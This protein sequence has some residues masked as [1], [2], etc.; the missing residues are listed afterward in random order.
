MAR[1]RIQPVIDWLKRII[2]E[3]RSELTRW[4]KAVRYAYDLGMCGTRQLKED[5]APQMAGALAYRTLFG[6]LP[7]VVVAT[8]LA[9]AL[10]GPDEFRG[11]L[12]RSITAIIQR[13][14]LSD[15]TISRS[16]VRGGEA[17]DQTLGD[18]LHEL[19]SPVADLNFTALGWI[20]VLIVIYA[21][22]S[23]MVTIEKS[24]N[25]VY[26][27]PEGRPWIWR[28][29]IYW[30]VLTISPLAIALTLYLDSSFGQLIETIDAWQW[31][32]TSATVL[33]SFAAAWLVMT[34]VYKL[35]P[36]TTVALRPA[37]AG[38]FIAALLLEIGKRTLGAYLENAISVS[39]LYG[40]LGLIPLFMFWVYL[41]WLVVLLGLEVSAILQRVAGRSLQEMEQARSRTGIVEPASVLTVMEI[42]A[43]RFGDSRTTTTADV[44]QDTGISEQMVEMMIGR[45]I[46]AGH[47]HRLAGESGAVNLA[48]PPE[49][50]ATADLMEVAFALVEEDAAGR[51]T[52]FRSRLRHAQLSLAEETTLAELL[53]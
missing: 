1:L 34:A 15:A 3:P 51:K 39:L 45:L 21:A 52:A 22:I 6:L 17:S 19:I 43:R 41:M 30:T 46:E 10:M 53:A 28:I 26:R 16:I 18:F 12:G 2:T 14:G 37:M 29:T 47:L 36:N 25:T 23:L 50:I 8:V 49:R 4:Q 35:V 5:R 42:I 40:S 27:T 24:F 13:L 7:V 33:W 48:R 44:A 9:K 31:V 20:G 32:L 11:F 38:A